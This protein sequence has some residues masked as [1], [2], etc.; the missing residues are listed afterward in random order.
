MAVAKPGI[1]KELSLFLGR[2]VLLA[3]VCLVLW[4]L[5][6][7]YYAWV[8]GEISV[9]VLRYLLRLPVESVT[10]EPSG[11]LNTETLLRFGWESRTREIAMC[12][13]VTNIA[14]FV[15]LVL[16][17]PR[18]ARLT[19]RRRLR[20]LALGTGILALGQEV[21]LILAFT[22]AGA[23]SQSPEFPTALAQVFITLPF[24]LWVVLAHW[25][26]MELFLH[27][28]ACKRSN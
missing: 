4:W 5:I 10:V 3:P 6:M 19:L 23:V 16:A 26:R 27:P 15:A 1:L 11:F 12:V 13:L 21:Y 2:L 24:P 25:D 9:V 20:T 18:G 22:F 28:N 14:T 7:P 8:L 17:T